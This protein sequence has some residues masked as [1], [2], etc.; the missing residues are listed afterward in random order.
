MQN[1]PDFIIPISH[2]KCVNVFITNERLLVL[3]IAKTIFIIVMNGIDYLDHNLFQEIPSNAG[4]TQQSTF[5][6]ARV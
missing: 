4:G 2:I 1:L 5:L 6:L 3:S